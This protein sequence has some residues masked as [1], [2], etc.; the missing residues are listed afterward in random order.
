MKG[1]DLQRKLMVASP[2]P[3]GIVVISLKSILLEISW[4]IQLFQKVI[5]TFHAISSQKKIV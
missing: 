2:Y 1:V 3:Q 4:N 5:W